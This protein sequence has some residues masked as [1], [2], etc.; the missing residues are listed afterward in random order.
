M[1]QRWSIGCLKKMKKIIFFSRTQVGIYGIAPMMLQFEL[2]AVVVVLGYLHPI[3]FERKPEEL[4]K[5][6]CGT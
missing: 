6:V 1:N 2:L 3:Y 4:Y 5:T